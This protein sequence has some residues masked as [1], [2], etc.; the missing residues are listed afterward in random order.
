MDRPPVQRDHRAAS[1]GRFG[2][3]GSGRKRQTV[4]VLR[5]SPGAD[6]LALGGALTRG[7]ASKQLRVK[8]TGLVARRSRLIEASIDFYTHCYSVCLF[9]FAMSLCESTCII[10]FLHFAVGVT[11][12]PTRLFAVLTAKT[13]T[14]CPARY[15]Y[16]TCRSTP[17][18][19]RH[20]QYI[21]HNAYHHSGRRLRRCQRLPITHSRPLAKAGHRRRRADKKAGGGYHTRAQGETSP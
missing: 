19:R 13:S 20:S 12:I 1:A 3:G 2:V 15:L 16:Y 8:Q 6:R 14:I 9:L 4:L 21:S 5:K 18:A 17:S 10:A 7:K 11:A